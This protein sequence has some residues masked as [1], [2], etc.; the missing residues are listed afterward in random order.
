MLYID[1]QPGAVHINLYLEHPSFAWFACL[2]ISV[3][4]DS[5]KYSAITKATVYTV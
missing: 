3:A 1:K 4:S 5:Y 2:C